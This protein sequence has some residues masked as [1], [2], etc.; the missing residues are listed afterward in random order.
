MFLPIKR[1]LMLGGA[2]AGTATMLVPR[3]G[4]TQSSAIKIGVLTDMSGPYSDTT[5]MGSVIATQMAVQDFMASHPDIRVEVI[6]ADMQNNPSVGLS[7]ARGWFDRDGVDA[8][9]DVGQSDI[10]LAVATLVRDKDKVALFGAP[11]TDALTG[12]ACGPNHVHWT[13][14]TWAFAAAIGRAVVATGGDTWFFVTADYAYG[15]ALENNTT[16]FIEEAGGKVVG[17]A[18]FPFPGTTDFASYLLQAQSSRAKIVG[19]AAGGG[20]LINCLKQAGEFGI[21]RG[22]QR[23]AGITVLINQI[24][25]LGLEATQGLVL[26]SPFYWDLNDGTRAF[27]HRFAAQFKGLMPTMVQ[28]GAYS[29]AI[30][31]LKAVEALGVDKAKASGRATVA[32]M[33]A[34]PTEDPLFGRGRVREDGRKIH[35]LYLFEVKSPADSQYPWDYY[36]KLRTI[37]S[38]QAFR[39]MADGG[40]PMI[41]I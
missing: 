26:V 19:F 6:S 5:G 21:V 37:P 16:R 13:F 40:C 12:K 8:V 14:D 28:A 4:R 34:M 38:E 3:A 22:G 24:I 27:S 35:D 1:R 9:T 2:A 15:H 17:H 30:H 33:K 11:G 10:A 39:P 7:I 41:H 20:D 18:T 29:D 36:K 23:L 25:S 32:Q 31:Y